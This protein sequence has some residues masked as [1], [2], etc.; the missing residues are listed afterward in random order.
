MTLILK[1]LIA[2][3][4]Y[5][6]NFKHLKYQFKLIDIIYSD[7]H[8]HKICL[9]QSSGKNIFLKLSA[10]DI[11]NNPDFL[12]RL[13]PRDIVSIARLDD[14]IEYMSKAH[15]ITIK[16]MVRGEEENNEPKFIVSEIGKENLMRLSLNEIIN[17][18]LTFSFKKEDIYRIG[19]L[20][21]ILDEKALISQKEKVKYNHMESKR[22]VRLFMV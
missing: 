6:F 3:I 1:K 2:T 17:Q 22:K 20:K 19:Y 4:K 18:E 14:E 16:E 9:I 13:S 10:Q 5:L 21:G 15:P 7:K 12:L 11:I 8:S